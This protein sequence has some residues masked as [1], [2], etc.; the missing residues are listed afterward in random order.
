MNNKPKLVPL[1]LIIGFGGYHTVEDNATGLTIRNR[2]GDALVTLDS[3]AEEAL[4]LW[5]EKK[6]GRGIPKAEPQADKP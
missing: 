2:Q 1:K 3:Q 4:L 5:L 6:Y